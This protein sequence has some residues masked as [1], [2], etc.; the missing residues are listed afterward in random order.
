MDHPPSRPTHLSAP[1][2][3]DRHYIPKIR[4]ALEE[5]RMTKARRSPG[6][7]PIEL[8]PLPVHC[9]GQGCAEETALLLPGKFP[10]RAAIFME[11]GWRT[12]NDPSDHSVVFVCGGCYE[13]VRAAEQASETRLGTI[14]RG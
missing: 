13:K 8:V 1:A 3:C 5:M 14:T 6:K 4:L 9:A 12:L 7:R 2:V 11:A 10:Y